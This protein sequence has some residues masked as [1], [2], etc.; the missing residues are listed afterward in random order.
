MENITMF[1]VKESKGN[2]N[3][4]WDTKIGAS[5]RPELCITIESANHNRAQIEKKFGLFGLE[6]VECEIKVK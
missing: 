4:F 6:V 3:R 2:G 5:T 1:T